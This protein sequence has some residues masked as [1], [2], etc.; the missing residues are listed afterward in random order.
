MRKK[1]IAVRNQKTPEMNELETDK[2]PLKICAYKFEKQKSLSIL[3]SKK[4]VVSFFCTTYFDM[5]IFFYYRSEVVVGIP[6]QMSL[7]T[8]DPEN[9][10][11]GIR[12]ISPENMSS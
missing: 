10:R 1:E 4:K 8:K 2:V 12:Q 9:E 6:P 11:I 3:K 7:G 5:I